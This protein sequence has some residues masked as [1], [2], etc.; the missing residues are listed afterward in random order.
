MIL[1]AEQGGGKGGGREN[2]PEIVGFLGF[3]KGPWEG[4]SVF[5]FLTGSGRLP[6]LGQFLVV[7]GMYK[8]GATLPVSPCRLKC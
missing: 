6:I 4:N 5:F 8:D 1:A 3:W 2:Y 7:D